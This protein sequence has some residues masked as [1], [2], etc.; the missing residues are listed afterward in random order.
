M[1]ASVTELIRRYDPSQ[2]LASACTIPSAWYLDPRIAA[3]RALITVFAGNWVAVA[4]ADQLAEPG[5]FVTAAVAGEPVVVVRGADR[6][7][8]AFFNVCRHHAAAVCTEPA[9]TARAL[10]C[11]Y[12]GWTYSL[13]GELKGVPEFDGVADFDKREYGLL[14]VACAA[15]QGFVFVRL[16]GPSPGLDAVVAELA[17]GVAG[18]ALDRLRFVERQTYDLACNWKVFVDNYLDGGY[19]VPHIHRDLNSVL[20]LSD[21]TIECGQR[22]CLQSG[23]LSAGGDAGTARVRRG[24]RAYYYWLYPNLMIN[25]YAGTMDTNVVWPLAVDRCRVVFDF[26]FDDSF[27]ADARTHSVA[28]AD[29]VQLEDVAVCESVQRGLASRAYDVGRLSVRREA[30]E[31]LFHRLLHADL[32]AGLSDAH[33]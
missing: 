17:A 29:R 32:E 6:L 33:G 21:Y 11:P 4:R 12:H 14:P 13:A 22:Y 18:L 19:H 7:L 27:A 10:H 15:W 26:Y 3:A 24:D 23:P 2:P 16:A 1:S 20:S 25:C 8:R 28:V 5:Q 9:G 31:Q 30:G